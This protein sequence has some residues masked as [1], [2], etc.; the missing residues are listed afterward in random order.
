KDSAY[1][2]QAEYDTLNAIGREDLVAFHKQYFQPENVI[3]GAW[4]DFKTD[5]MRAK[6]EKALGGWARGGRPKPAVPAVDPGASKRTG[7]YFIN[8]EDATQSWVLM[9]M[10]A[11]KRND[12]DFY[13]LSVMN[14]IL[15]G[16]L[17]SRMFSNIRS[18]EGLAYAVSS[19]WNA[20]WDRPGIFTAL[21]G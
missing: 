18:D 10:L 14:T 11:G 13:A 4:G 6:L 16:G 20:G 9:G 8:K 12:Q 21:G 1:G 3:L 15:G 7:L 17:S 2:H 19:N 5:E